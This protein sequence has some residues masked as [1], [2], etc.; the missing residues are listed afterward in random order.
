MP[1]R[2]NPD[3]SS[4]QKMLEL[5]SLLLFSGRRHTLTAL[6]ER[7]QCSKTTIERLVSEIE[8]FEE[9]QLGKEG[10]ER[11]FQVNRLR[12]NKKIQIMHEQVQHLSLCKDFSSCILPECIMEEV[13][14][15][16]THAANFISDG[17]IKK[18]SLQPLARSSA[19]G[20][21]DYTPFQRFITTIMQAIPKKII[22]EV[23]YQGLKSKKPRKFIIAPMRFLS[24]HNSLYIE[25]WKYKND[26]VDEVLQP[27]T[28][29]I[30]RIM[31]LN[32]TK[33]RHDIIDL[34]ENA[35]GNFGLIKS[36]S[37]TIVVHFDEE[38]AR[39][40]SEREWSS[41][42]S[43][44]IFPSGDIELTYTAN[45]I[46]E[47]ISWILSFGDKAE[48]LEPLKLRDVIIGIMQSS[49]KKYNLRS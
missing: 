20:V 2:L 10:R 16:I 18:L 31:S 41:N 9:V 26:C 33:K 3:A 48:V 1:A 35:N 11:W 39:Y 25:C 14:N 27:M 24:Y 29:A 7:M 5:Y 46:E 47:A 6:S 32:P 21:I 36:E 4:S 37:L 28:L 23:V 38:V 43:I 40:V 22:C 8:I 34:P 30:Q 42:Q 17:D 15:T 19:K 13:K 12:K 44:T 49:L 45:G